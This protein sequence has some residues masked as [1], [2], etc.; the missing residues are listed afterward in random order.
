MTVNSKLLLGLA[1]LLG[2]LA[3][4]GAGLW[5]LLSPPQYAATAR[6]KM[7]NDEP[8]S[9]GYISYDP[10]FIQTTFEIMQ[11]QL[12]LSNVVT[13]LNL[14]E[15]WGRN[16]FN[17]EPL[18]CAEC[19]AILRNH[20]C[21]TPVRNTRFVDITYYSSDPKEA[22]DVANAIAKAYREFR[23]RSL[24]ETVAKGIEVLQQMYKDEETQI[25][26]QPTNSE[27]ML[28]LHKLLAEKIEAMKIEPIPKTVTVQF[29][30]PAEPPQFPVRT[31]RPLGAALLAVGLFPLLG[32]ILL[33]KTK[34]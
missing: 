23:I 21:L 14:N 32:G 19:Y 31:N 9:S 28:G 13:S 33:L 12:V 30:D 1:L 10:Y 5:L 24:K 7:E 17:G 25:S 11:S 29:V 4:C 6:I 15:V 27:Q 18:K 3:L 34:P 20:L 26:L 8:D 2:G 16:N 22:A